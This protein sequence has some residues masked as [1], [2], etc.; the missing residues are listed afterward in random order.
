V[1]EGV[2]VAAVVGYAV[3]L[4]LQHLHKLQITQQL[5]LLCDEMTVVR[6][7]TTHKA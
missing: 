3:K 7:F 5:Q 4:Q 6:K 2:L 1:H